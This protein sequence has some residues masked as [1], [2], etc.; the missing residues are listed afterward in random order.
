VSAAPDIDAVLDALMKGTDAEKFAA[1]AAM[2]RAQYDRLRQ[3]VARAMGIRCG[4]LDIEVERLRRPSQGNGHDRSG[5]MPNEIVEQMNARH[6]LIW[7]SGELRV[8]WRHEW[9]GGVPR[10]SSVN[11]TRLYYRN[12]EIRD[13]N[14]VDVWIE[15]LERCEFD[16]IAFEP[17]NTD[18]RVFNLWRGWSNTPMVGDCSLILAHIKNAICSGYRASIWMRGSRQSR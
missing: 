6:A 12:Q 1:L 10:T 14:P 15:S 11:S 5:Q 8:L 18:P 9:D 3:P 13:V 16:H 17:G 7:Q 4:T 2:P